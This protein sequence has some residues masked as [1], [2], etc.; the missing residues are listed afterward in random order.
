MNVNSVFLGQ[1]FC[2]FFGGKKRDKF[3]FF[4]SVNSTNSTNFTNFLIS[5]NRKKNPGYRLITTYL[6]IIF[7]WKN[8][9]V[10]STK[11]KNFLEKCVLYCKFYLFF[12]KL[13][14]IFDLKKLGKKTMLMI[15]SKYNCF[16]NLTKNLK[17]L[18][19][20][21]PP[22]LFYYYITIKSI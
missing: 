16:P 5:E 8:I 22:L 13:Y 7:S 14:H 2:P 3:E 6:F 10:L 4:A 19:W 11:N 21:I 9:V 15:P 18:L 12:G 1:F 17:C 20:S